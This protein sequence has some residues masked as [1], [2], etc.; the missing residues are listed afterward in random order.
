M[1]R[2]STICLIATCSLFAGCAT[3]VVV[4]PADKQVRWLKPGDTVTT[5]N[6]VWLVP[7]ARMQEILRALNQP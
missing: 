2:L 4:V 1:R 6:G 5:E 3:R 7:D